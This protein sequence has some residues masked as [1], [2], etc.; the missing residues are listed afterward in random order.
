MSPCSSKVGEGSDFPSK[1]EGGR[2]D[3]KIMRKNH[4]KKVSNTEKRKTVKREQNQ[5]PPLLRGKGLFLGGGRAVC[6]WKKEAARA[7]RSK[8]KESLCAKGGA[9][10]SQETSPSR[11]GKKREPKGGS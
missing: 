10:P 11:R 5:H 2:R 7:D 1:R 6:A 3:G 8:E 9:N 4:S